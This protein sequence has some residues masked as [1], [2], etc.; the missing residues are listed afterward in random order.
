[1]EECILGGGKGKADSDL[2]P[3]NLME[4]CD[5]MEDMDALG[6][7]AG[8]IISRK[9]KK[10]P[11]GPRMDGEGWVMLPWI[12]PGGPGCGCL[13]LLRGSGGMDCL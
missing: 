3:E 6:W 9:S 1:M 4:G 5:Q 2:V 10:S 11:G 12:F 8:G 13:D 7:C